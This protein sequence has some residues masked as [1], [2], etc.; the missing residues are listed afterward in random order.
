M[1]TKLDLHQFIKKGLL[2]SMELVPNKFYFAHSPT[3]STVT[4]YIKFELTSPNSVRIIAVSPFENTKHAALLPHIHQSG[5]HTGHIFK[6]V[7]DPRKHPDM[8]PE[9][10]AT[11]PH[12]AELLMLDGTPYSVDNP[13]VISEYSEF[14]GLNNK[15]WVDGEHELKEFIRE[16]K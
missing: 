2:E 1:K 6:F 5:K 10:L 8:N 3:T 4:H 12:I 9:Q 15:I 11:P 7:H 16:E 13:E 14:K